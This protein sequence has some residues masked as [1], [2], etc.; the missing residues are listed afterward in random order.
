MRKLV[1]A[2]AS[3]A[4]GQ[5]APAAPPAGFQL[6]AM[7]SRIEV[8]GSGEVKYM[9]DVA[10]ISYSIRGEG[11]TSDDA[12]RAM[13]TSASLIRAAVRGVDNNAEPK[14]SE[15]KIAQVKSVECRDQPYGSPQLST[16]ACAISGYVATHRLCFEL[17]P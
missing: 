7:P 5:I 9:P 11:A 17:R 15:V 16:G 2:F 1:I 14:T 6:T 13:T 3:L 12:V 8:G 4:V 10:T